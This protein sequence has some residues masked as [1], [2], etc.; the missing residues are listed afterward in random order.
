MVAREVNNK[1]CCIFAFLQR[2][3]AQNSSSVLC[4]KVLCCKATFHRKVKRTY[5]TE[6]IL[7]KQKDVLIEAYASTMHLDVASRTTHHSAKL[8]SS[9]FIID[10]L[11]TQCNIFTYLRWSPR[12]R[13]QARTTRYFFILNL[14]IAICYLLFAHSAF[15]IPH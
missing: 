13:R 8:N 4:R 9:K 3:V 15:R 5:F 10:S 6:Y 1:S 11:K 7:F 12:L 14:Q 2:K